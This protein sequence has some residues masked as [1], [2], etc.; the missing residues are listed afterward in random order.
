MAAPGVLQSIEAEIQNAHVLS[1]ADIR[2]AT[3]L[4]LIAADAERPPGFNDGIVRPFEPPSDP[5]G[6]SASLAAM[7][8]AST[9]GALH[10][11]VLLVDFDDNAG[12]TA[13][14][15]FDSL[16]FDSANP[17]SLTAYYHELSQGR[18][19]VTG[20]VTAWIRAPK[21]YSF[22][23]AGQNGTGKQF[24]RNT[25]GLLFDALTTYCQ[26]HSLAPFDSNQD[27]FVDGIFLVF[28]GGG[29]EAEA[30]PIV[31]R[32][33]IWSH[34]W[35]LPQPFQADGVSVYAY[36]TEPEDGKLGVFTHEFGHSLGLPDLYDT[37]YRSKGAGLWCLM[38]GGS[39]GGSGHQPTRLS[40]WCL[41]KLG[42]I[43]PQ[44]GSPGQHFLLPPLAQDPTACV[45]LDP[46][47]GSGV[48][49]FL[50][51]NRQAA[52]RDSALP[53]SGLALWHIDDA[54]SDNSNPLAYHVGLV[55]AD[56][57]RDLEMNRNDGDAGDLLPGSRGV[58]SIN[59]T[60]HP[61]TTLHDGS[62]SGVSLDNISALGAAIAFDVALPA[63]QREFPS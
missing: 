55:Q 11:L 28:A 21:P 52:D 33:K 10:A 40:A 24:P 60:T 47:A 34:K 12:T 31:R 44:A 61:S 39:W 8:P 6:A 49:Y 56:G 50:V 38:A 1:A 48:E 51:E 14:S 59:D 43:Q 32:N 30:D 63:R 26:T 58:T 42:W 15:H 5:S 53:G 22:Y 35:V 7:A 46:P 20:E 45:R 13:P 9:E 18:L 23:T 19:R 54:R 25:P 3:A 36:S 17:D 41:E 37:S 57:R 27:G 16:L 29:A 62:A 2:L 4:G